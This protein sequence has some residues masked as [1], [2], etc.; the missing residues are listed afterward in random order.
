MNAC[1]YCGAVTQRE[2]NFCRNCGNRLL[3]ATP[4]A[5]QSARLIV[6][7]EDGKDLLEYQLEKLKVSIGRAASCD[8]ILTKDKLASLRHATL[9][10]E[11]G[12]YVLYDECS[13][14]GTFVNGEQIGEAIPYVLQDGNH[15][16]IGE[17]EFIFRLSQ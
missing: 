3:D 14:N 8:L 15:I 6:C 17:H 16:G 1:P 4:S 13:A 7:G 10:Y 2:D 11:D 12:R 9:S 5:S